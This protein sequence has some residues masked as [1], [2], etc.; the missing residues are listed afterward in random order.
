M[1]ILYALLRIQFASD[2]SR[3]N[4]TIPKTQR[5]NPYFP[6][7]EY[8]MFAKPSKNADFKLGLFLDLFVAAAM[9]SSLCLYR[10]PQRQRH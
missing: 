5:Y 10:L 9:I 3:L 4:H 7:P 8:S 1:I 6:F 2:F